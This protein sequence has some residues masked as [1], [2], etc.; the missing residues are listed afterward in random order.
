[1]G[2]EAEHE[3]RPFLFSIAYRMVGSVAEAE[4]LVQEAFMRYQ[5][6][7]ATVES[8]RAY[9]AAVTTRLAI[10]HLRSAR[11]R[12][13]TYPGQWLPEPI[14]AETPADHAEMADSLSL[15]FL[16]LLERLSPVERAVFLLREV[17]GYEY[18]EIAR[19]VDRTEVNCRQ[20][21]ARARAHVDAGRPRFDASPE[22]RQALA[23]RF[24]AACEDGDASTLLELLAEDATVIGDGGGKRPSFPQPVVGRER[25]ARA[26]ASFVARARSMAVVRRP[27]WVNGQPGAVFYDQDGHVVWVSSLDIVDGKVAAIRS[28]LNPDKLAH[29]VPRP[30]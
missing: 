16:T 12:R 2:M 10:D 17:F 26:L 30:S 14:V 28:V 15:A 11:V 7:D 3:L 5:Q 20:I 25:I 27:V 23:A 9:L 1:M 29:V 22:Q 21:L 24:F 6:A 8:P 19:A 13:E 18:D 4:D